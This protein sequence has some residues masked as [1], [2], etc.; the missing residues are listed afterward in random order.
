MREGSMK[1]RLVLGDGA[2]QLLGS[3]DDLLRSPT[4]NGTEGS[5]IFTSS[6]VVSG[7]PKVAGYAAAG[8]AYRLYGGLRAK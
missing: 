8:C 1:P 6:L 4:Y 3:A 7:V 5:I 2:H